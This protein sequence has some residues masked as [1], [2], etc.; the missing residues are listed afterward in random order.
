MPNESKPEAAASAPTPARKKKKRSPAALQRE[1]RDLASPQD[2]P[3]KPAVDFKKVFLRVGIIVLALW[4]AAVIAL[5][6]TIIPVIVAGALTLVATGAMVW[7]V[8][9]VNKSRELGALLRSAA[10]TEE[11]RVEAL[12]KLET[13]FKKG[14][15]QATIARAQL[16]MQQDPRQALATLE[17]IDLAKQIAPM[18]DQVRC[19][20]ASLHLQLGEVQEARALV[21][22][23]ELG[24]QQEV[25]TRVMFAAVAGEAWGRTGEARKAV[26]LLEVFN[27]DD[28]DYGEMRIQMWRARAFAYAGVG[29]MKGASRALRKLSE[30]SPQLLA[31][32]VAGKRVHPMLQQE[33]KQLFVRSGAVARKMVRQKV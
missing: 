7:I 9:Y 5:R 23:M 24:K 32:F 25:K 12:K 21:D 4:V 17:S 18:A 30:I 27:P 16:Q 2:G 22:K 3:A 15:V 8:R 19:L 31:M 1:L 10:A 26:E 6:W 33:A 13:D 14:D 11:G 28:P 29:D 20:R